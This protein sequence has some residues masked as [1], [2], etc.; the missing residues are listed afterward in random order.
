MWDEGGVYVCVL[1]SV[2]MMAF[3][4]SYEI[5]LSFIDLIYYD[6]VDLG[7]FLSLACSVGYDAQD[8]F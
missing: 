7:L 3:S 8:M 4:D 6:V 2:P 1:K 5:G